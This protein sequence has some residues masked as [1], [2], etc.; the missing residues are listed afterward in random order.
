MGGGLYASRRPV[1]VAMDLTV[2]ISGFLGN[3]AELP[4]WMKLAFRE[5]V[6]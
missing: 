1:F 6:D 4:R 5:T 3:E 2:R